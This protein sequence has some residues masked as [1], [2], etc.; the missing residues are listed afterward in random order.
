[1][2]SNLQWV[3]S[4]RI[5]E[6]YTRRRRK[7]YLQIAIKG[8]SCL[9][10]HFYLPFW[11]FFPR[12]QIIHLPQPNLKFSHEIS[13]QMKKKKKWKEK[14]LKTRKFWTCSLSK[15]WTEKRADQRSGKEWKT[16]LFLA[17]FHDRATSAATLWALKG[18]NACNNS[19]P[20]Y[21]IVRL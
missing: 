14:Y 21:I 10:C 20:K 11:F 19:G 5:E 2:G 15:P 6:K 1:M 7:H 12:S 13:S 9:I 17:S 4:I 8:G 16:L 3:I 18:T